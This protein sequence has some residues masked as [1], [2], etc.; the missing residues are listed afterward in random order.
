MHTQE[1][2]ANTTHDQHKHTLN[3]RVQVARA[4]RAAAHAEQTPR[5]SN[6]NTH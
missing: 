1:C 6:T 3:T 2:T 5:M 4:E